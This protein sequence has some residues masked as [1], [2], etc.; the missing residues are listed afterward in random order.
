MLARGAAR[1]QELA[2]RAA[3]GGSRW[4]LA[5]QL[6]IES[7]ILALAGGAIGL[8]SAQLVTRLLV[9]AAPDIVARSA[10]GAGWSLPVFAFGFVA[11]LVSG[12]AFGLMPALQNTRPSLERVLR[13]SSRGASH[14]RGQARFRQALVVC[15]IGLA[16]VLV[17]GAGLLLRSF[18]RLARAHLGLEPA[19]VL[20]FEVNLPTGRYGAPERR[21]VFHVALQERLAAI[22][23]VRA[24]GAVSRLPVTGMYH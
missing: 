16:L 10:A 3:L 9:A 1:G 23:G 12:L 21:A 17:T 13:A 14:G 11:A 2:V 24:A 8:V 5:R 18:D 15:Q 4:Q 19:D 22:P 6:L 7:L 20:T